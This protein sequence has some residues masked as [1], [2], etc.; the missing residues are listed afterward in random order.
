MEK[1]TSLEFLKIKR[2]LEQGGRTGQLE[3]YIKVEK[4]S[5]SVVKYRAK[6]KRLNK[7]SAASRRKNR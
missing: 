3:K 6:R 2:F 7:I 1:T 5:K 4:I